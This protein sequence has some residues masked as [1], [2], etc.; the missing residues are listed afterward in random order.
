MPRFLLLVSPVTAPGPLAAWVA[1]HAARGVVRSGARA[2]AGTR[3]DRGGGVTTVGA[4]PPR[5]GYLVVEAEDDA[6]GLAIAAS[7]PGTEAG[8]IEL[9]RLDPGETI[10]E[11]ASDATL[12]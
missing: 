9:Y 8:A 1:A 10:G 11:A 3:L 6:A 2:L 4:A 7:C 5:W 12:R